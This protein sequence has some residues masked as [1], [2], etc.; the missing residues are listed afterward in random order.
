MIIELIEPT[1]ILFIQGFLYN[2]ALDEFEIRVEVVFYGAVV[3]G[4]GLE[5]D[6]GAVGFEV[7]EVVVFEGGGNVL[8]E[9]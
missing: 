2:R 8:D 6:G 4:V 3:L 9:F 7:L 1:S 5:V